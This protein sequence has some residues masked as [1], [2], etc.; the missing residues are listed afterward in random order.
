M[1]VDD[2]RFLFYL[3]NNG[4]LAGT[5]NFRGTSNGKES[6]LP[7]DA[8]ASFELHIYQRSVFSQEERTWREAWRSPTTTNRKIKALQKRFGIPDENTKF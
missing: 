8:I 4:W 7:P 5:R 3:T 6:G 2:V 1:S